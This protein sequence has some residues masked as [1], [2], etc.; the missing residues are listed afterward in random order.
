MIYTCSGKPLS[1]NRKAPL[2]MSHGSCPWHPWK[3]KQAQGKGK[4][5]DS[6]GWMEPSIYLI[7]LAC[8]INDGTEAPRVRCYKSGKIQEW[9]VGVLTTCCWVTLAS[10]LYPLCTSFLYCKV[11]GGLSCRLLRVCSVLPTHITICDST[12]PTREIVTIS[13]V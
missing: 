12:S 8:F 13:K 10:P 11:R 2:M 3:I 4:K 9:G 1:I 6:W 7:Q 5:I